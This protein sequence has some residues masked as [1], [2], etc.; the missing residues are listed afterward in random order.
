VRHSGCSSN[1]LVKERPP[2]LDVI[3]IAAGIG[4]F[5]AGILYAVACEKI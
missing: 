5:A 4:L 1:A 2:M 3:L